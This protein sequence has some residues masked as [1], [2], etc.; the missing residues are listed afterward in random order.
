[1]MMMMMIIIIIIIINVITDRTVHNNRPDIVTLD[2]TVKAAQLVDAAIANSHNLRSTITEKFQKY[3]DLTE[4]L[5]R[6]WQLQT[7]CTVPPVLFTAGIIPNKLHD[8]LKLLSLRSALYIVMQKAVIL[9]RY[10]VVRNV[11]GRTVNKKCLVCE[12]VLF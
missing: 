4:E 3:T 12:T 2:K 11:C 1:M 5:V 6:I 9:N 7:A 8:S 10:C